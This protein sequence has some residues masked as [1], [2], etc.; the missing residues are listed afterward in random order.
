MVERQAEGERFRAQAVDVGTQQARLVRL[1]RP[2]TFRQFPGLKFQALF[3]GGALAQVRVGDG[4]G[5]LP[6][7]ELQLSG[8]N[9]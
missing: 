7:D 8:N 4:R 2:P 3:T 1:E 6:V 5:C 9:T